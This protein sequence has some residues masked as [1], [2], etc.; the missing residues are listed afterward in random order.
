MALP[1]N[2]SFGTI[3]GRFM[4][5]VADGPDTGRDPDGIPLAGL[6]V[7]FIPSSGRFKNA[8][9]TP[10]VMIVADPITAT[11]DADGYL[12]DAEGEQGIRLLATDD[13][14]LNPTGWTWG[15]AI[16]GT[17]F[18]TVS[19]SFA[20]PTDGTI[21]LATVVPVPGNPGQAMQDWLA[22]VEASQTA[23]AD[24]LVARDEAVSAKNAAEAVPT[25]SDGIMAANV[26]NGGEFDTKLSAT[27]VQ[28][29]GIAGSTG[30]ANVTFGGHTVEITDGT[31]HDA[32]PGLV[33]LDDG[34]LVGM[35]RHATHHNPT[36]DIGEPVKGVL[37]VIRSTDRG[38][39]WSAPQVA[40]EHPTTDTRDPAL[41]LL[42]DG[43]IAAVFFLHTGPIAI[44][45]E[46]MFSADG[47]V[48]WGAPQVVPFT[49]T[50]AS[51]CSGPLVETAP[52][53]WC[54]AAYGQNTGDSFWSAR[55]I[56]TTDGGATWQDE[57]TIADG[58]TESRTFT[59]PFLGARADGSLMCLVR[60]DTGGREIL[61]TVST[62][63]GATWSPLMSVLA[64]HGRPS[65]LQ[66]ASGGI[67]C[68]FRQFGGDGDRPT[69]FATSW[70]GGATW[71]APEVLM[72]AGLE[73]T[74]A[75][76][77]E[78]S[79]GLVAVLGSREDL[80]TSSTVYLCYLLDGNGI[81]PLADV[82]IGSGVDGRY[83]PTN[84]LDTLWCGAIDAYSS[85][86]SPVQAVIG[87]LPGYSMDPAANETIS[88]FVT[89]PD[90]WS[91]V[92][93]DLYWATSTA[94]GGDIFVQLSHRAVSDGHATSGGDTTSFA[95]TI[96]APAALTV[97]V[98]R[99][100][101]ASSAFLPGLRTYRLLRVGAVAGDTL[102]G[103]ALFLGM[104]LTRAS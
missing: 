47:G 5:A 59:E 46:L 101:T 17:G 93:V 7:K 104:L 2:V 12:I 37:H 22:A 81:S 51:A 55:T 48:T 76:L 11:T 4:R 68:V 9:A 62:D 23:A 1:S 30:T 83:L 97:K 8:T 90:H 27:F 87:T 57:V 38:L 71:T 58:T 20:L 16:S 32:F 43:R 14:D 73:G 26:G 96:I 102:A 60:E 33:Q 52:G 13:E 79:P 19:F 56:R 67:V 70:D 31:M 77:V 42:S 54:V 40:Y 36:D 3:V 84:A 86:G 6:T 50:K 24:A 99:L 35:Y 44:P 28:Q 61:R 25:T 88:G 66:L 39:T 85:G 75:Q 41:T 69:I 10:P 15:V 103:D 82:S 78:T 98:S 80:R 18:R 72:P 95:G 65:W 91:S 21:D 100:T 94:T 34:T 89:I 92:N 63:D 53:Q 45:V 49:F 64:G 74:Y 29:S